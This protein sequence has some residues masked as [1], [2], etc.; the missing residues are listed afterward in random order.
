[1]LL[2]PGIEIE[3]LVAA[4]HPAPARSVR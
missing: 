4:A 3:R 1:M 2:L